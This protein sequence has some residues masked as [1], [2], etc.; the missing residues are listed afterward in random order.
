MLPVPRYLKA[1]Q[2]RLDLVRG[3]LDGVDPLKDRGAELR[4]LKREVVEEL[5]DLFMGVHAGS[6]PAATRPNIANRSKFA[7]DFHAREA[8]GST[9]IAGGLAIPHVRT[10]QARLPTLVVAR[11]RE[12]VWYDA[13]DGRPTR[14]FFGISAP[15]WEEEW[16]GTFYRWIGQAFRT[17]GDWLPDALLSA[18]TAD[19]MVGLLASA[20]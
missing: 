5:V 18:G 6:D 19:E 12:G 11:S 4:R 7:H 13:P 16:Y 8:K 20:G 10:R 9:A 15:P 17:H 2:V 14:L 1:S 3:R